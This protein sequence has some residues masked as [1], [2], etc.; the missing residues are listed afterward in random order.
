[1]RFRHGG[2]A[3]LVASALHPSSNR[4]SRL[5]AARHRCGGLQQEQGPLQLDRDGES[6]LE[7]LKRLCS[8]ISGTGH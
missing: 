2:S 5:D 6:I 7:K 3:A 8:Q 4:Q 1:M